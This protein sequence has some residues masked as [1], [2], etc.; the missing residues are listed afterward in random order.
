MVQRRK[1]HAAN[2]AARR[3]VTRR[4]YADPHRLLLL[5]CAEG[6]ARNIVMSYC[7]LRQTR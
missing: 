4:Q 1:H 6:G 7:R 2:G 3:S 5:H